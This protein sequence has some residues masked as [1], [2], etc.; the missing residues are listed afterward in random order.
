MPQTEKHSIS[1]RRD[2]R[3][4]DALFSI[5]DMKLD[6]FVYHGSRIGRG[7]PSSSGSGISC[8]AT[9]LAGT[10]CTCLFFC[11]ETLWQLINHPA[12]N[13]FLQSVWVNEALGAVSLVSKENKTPERIKRVGEVLRTCFVASYKNSGFRSSRPKSGFP[14]NRLQSADF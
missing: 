2:P 13:P 6:A 8:E 11:A 4:L 10:C 1:R 12:E 3:C 14:S 9:F 5:N 7:V